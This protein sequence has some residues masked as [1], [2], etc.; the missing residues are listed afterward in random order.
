MKY[1]TKPNQ[2]LLNKFTLLYFIGFEIFLFLSLSGHFIARKSM[3]SVPD[4]Y[5]VHLAVIT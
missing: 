3:T 4:I 2:E 5:F 1:Q